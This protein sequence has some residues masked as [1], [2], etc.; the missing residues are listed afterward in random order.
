[1]MRSVLIALIVTVVA[2]CGYDHT[3]D[4]RGVRASGWTWSSSKNPSYSRVEWHRPPMAR[5]LYVGSEKFFGNAPR[6]T[7]RLPD[8]RL[9][10][11]GHLTAGTLRLL[12]GT[13]DSSRRS[14]EPRPTDPSLFRYS[15]ATISVAF[16]RDNK[17]RRIAVWKGGNPSRDSLHVAIG[18]WNG[19]KF[20]E[21]P[22]TR[23]E[24]VELFGRPTSE[25][26]TKTS[27]RFRWGGLGGS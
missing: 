26:S 24:L 12:V 1:M 14:P 8:G 15:N 21:L 19:T 3:L 11:P 23:D 9:L 4:W 18:N 25:R 27:G 6:F 17:L 5:G 20:V 13:P 2:G 22:A 16:D 10:T 7:V